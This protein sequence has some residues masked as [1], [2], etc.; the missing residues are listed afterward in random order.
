AC[1]F[2][3]RGKFDEGLRVLRD[4]LVDEGEAPELVN[5]PILGEQRSLKSR[6]LKRSE[7]Q[8]DQYRPIDLDGRA[9]PA[10][11]LIDEA[12]FEVAYPHRTEGGLGKIEHLVALRWSL[13]R[14]QIGL[15]VAIER[16]L[17]GLVAELLAKLEL[18]GDFR[19]PGGRDEGRKP[20][21]PRHDPILDL[22]R[23]NL[24]GP[25]DDGRCT[26]TAFEHRSLATGKRGL[27]AIRPTEVFR[28]VVG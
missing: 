28:T 19:I 21:K 24:A 12:I 23:W 20:G 17:V 8:V 2:L 13:A 27:A 10:I 6:S 11:W 18:V 25:A 15:V 4:F 9:K 7:A 5:P 16:H 22:A 1:A 14:D 26:K 3:H